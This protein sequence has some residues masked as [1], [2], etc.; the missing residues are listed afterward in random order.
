MTGD[1]LSVITKELDRTGRCAGRLIIRNG[2]GIQQLHGPEGIRHYKSW[3]LTISL[4]PCTRLD[5]IDL[6]QME[7]RKDTVQQIA[8]AYYSHLT[9]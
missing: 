5:N 7:F 3:P 1:I 6:S 9:C 2:Y 4:V 8:D